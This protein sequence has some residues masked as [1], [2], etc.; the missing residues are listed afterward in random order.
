L[1]QLLLWLV[2]AILGLLN[3]SRVKFLILITSPWIIYLTI[4]MTPQIL[5]ESVL[6][7]LIGLMGILCVLLLIITVFLFFLK[8]DDP[9]SKIEG[10][11]FG[12]DLSAS[13]TNL[14]ID[15]FYIELLPF[16]A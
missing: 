7:K 14:S 5:G 6:F 11:S 3:V 12:K 13:V 1:T 9:V 8:K 4:K 16:L 10:F 2:I 15:D